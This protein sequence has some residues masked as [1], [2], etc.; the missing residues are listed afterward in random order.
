MA[1]EVNKLT[2]YSIRALTEAI[3]DKATTQSNKLALG[4]ATL[5]LIAG[6]IRRNEPIDSD[7]LPAIEDAIKQIDK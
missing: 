6:M 1:N 7:M 5:R 4:A 3:Q 2:D